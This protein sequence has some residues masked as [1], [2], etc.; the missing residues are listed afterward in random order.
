M[1]SVEPDKQHDLD[2]T[3]YFVSKS[4]LWQSNE[5][6]SAGI[7]CE[8]RGESGFQAFEYEIRAIITIASYYSP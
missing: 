6:H 1:P 2:F 8:L 3:F 5:F 7:I 4:C